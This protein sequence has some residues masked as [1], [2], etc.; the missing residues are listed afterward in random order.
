VRWDRF[1]EDLEDQLDSEWEA[2]RA[3]LDSEA[4]RL[5]VSRVTLRE[6]LVALAQVGE[7]PLS[8]DLVDATVATGRVEAV[9]A[10]WISLATETRRAGGLLVP[11]HAV[12]A[13][14][15]AQSDAVVTAREASAGPALRQRMSFGFVLRDLARK[16]VPVGIRVSTGRT[17]TGTIDRAGADHLDLALHDAGAPR[18]RG[19]VA[20]YRLVSLAAVVCVRPDAPAVLP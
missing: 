14:G 9:G 20:G 13:V 3:A 15:M 1:F 19:D 11:L 5:R 17:L 7:S 18:R 2:E 10:D 8:L 6:R 12:V 4:E 16:R